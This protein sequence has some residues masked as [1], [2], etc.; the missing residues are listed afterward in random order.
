MAKDISE[1]KTNLGREMDTWFLRNEKIATQ[2]IIW[3]K[4]EDQR[5]KR[6]WNTTTNT[7]KWIYKDTCATK[8]SLGSDRDRK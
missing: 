8:F 5:E 4:S 3:N 1:R 7:T 2:P 6:K